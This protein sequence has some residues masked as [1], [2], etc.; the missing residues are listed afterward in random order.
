MNK[1]EEILV[2]QMPMYKAIKG[3]FATFTLEDVVR[4][5]TRMAGVMAEGMCGTLSPEEVNTNVLADAAIAGEDVVLT[6]LMCAEAEGYAS[7]FDE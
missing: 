1:A 4:I 3:Q 5:A 6:A 2:R 7:S